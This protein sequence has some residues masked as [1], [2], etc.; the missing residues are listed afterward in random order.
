MAQD[1]LKFA[2]I[3]ILISG[4]EFQVFLLILSGYYF[5]AQAKSLFYTTAIIFYILTLV[6]NSILFALLEPI[7][8]AYDK[9]DVGKLIIFKRQ[10]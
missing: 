7:I 1:R 6:I 2:G 8:N 3:L 10:V 5:S 4:I 9:N